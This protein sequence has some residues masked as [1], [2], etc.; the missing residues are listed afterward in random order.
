MVKAKIIKLIRVLSCTGFRKAL[1]STGVAASTEHLEF[2]KRVAAYDID[3]IDIGANR[4]QFALAAREYFPKAKIFSFEPLSEPARMLKKIFYGDTQTHI[5]EMAIGESEQQ[6]TIHVSKS[7]DSSSLLPISSMQSEIFPGTEE[8]E[9]RTIQVM[10]LDAV[11]SADEIKKPALLKID[12]QGYE[13]QVIKG[14]EKLLPLIDH[15]YVECS[16]LPLYDG[17]ALADEII[18]LLHSHG[19][20]LDGIYNLTYGKDGSPIQGDFYFSR[21]N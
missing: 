13:R 4:G 17:Q 11:L 1:F 5:F 8:K 6:S 12:V 14:C 2:L 18:D 20:R 10:P 15:V 19:L 3:V 21:N 16:F 9:K 7:D